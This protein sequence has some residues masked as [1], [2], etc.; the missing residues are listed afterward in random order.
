[1]QKEIISVLIT[2]QVR[3]N[4]GRGVRQYV[5][6]PIEKEGVHVRETSAL[7]RRPAARRRPPLQDSIH[8]L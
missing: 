1:L 2:R 7:V 3:P 5:L 6:E 4:H 8:N